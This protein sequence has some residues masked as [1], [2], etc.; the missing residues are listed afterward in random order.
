[1]STQRPAIDPPHAGHDTSSDHN[2]LNSKTAPDAKGPYELT[3][4]AEPA[5]ASRQGQ[6]MEGALGDA[7]L[8][9]L[10]IRK[11]PKSD[12]HDP[13]AVRSQGFHFSTEFG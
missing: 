2:S 10:R 13:D 4:S 12:A 5:L 3:S 11:G 6:R 7:V 1:M 8:R 9:F